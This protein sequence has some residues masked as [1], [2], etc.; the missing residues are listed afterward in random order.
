MIKFYLNGQR[1]F[2][3]RGCEA[4]VRSTVSLLKRKFGDVQV[5]VPSDNISLDK[6]QWEDYDEYGVKF[7]PIYYPKLTRVWVQ[8][9]RLPL[10]F[11]KRMN[12]PFFVTPELKNI[13]MNI[14]AVISIGG[15]MYTYE[16]RLPAWIMGVDSIA[17]KY[18]KPVILWGASISDFHQEP[19]FKEVLQKHFKKMSRLIV[20]ESISQCILKADFDIESAVKMPDSAFTLVSQEVSVDAF[21]P[22][23]EGN[24]VLGLNVSPLIE[25]LNNEKFNIID[26]ISNFVRIVI[27][28]HGL[29]VLFVPHVTPLDGSEKNSDYHYM[30]RILNKLSDLKEQIG[31]MD[32]SLN[33]V[34]TKYVISQCR[35]FVGART[36][37]TIAA[38]SSEVPTVSIAYSTKAKGIN[39]DLFGSKPVVVPLND[40]SSENLLNAVDYL[41]E[42]EKE[43]KKELATKILLLKSR[44]YEVTDQLDSVF[45]S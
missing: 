42:N 28:K 24:G 25:K 7:V 13:L 16:G 9:Q 20:R 30:M 23:N 8:L 39:A 3:N 5:Y 38:F 36:H 43:I 15:D 45:L 29:S 19:E 6:K 10:K 34:Q 21:W 14:D 37:S 11:I 27:E 4:L 31:I 26:E 17:M 22:N 18:D 1:T 2:S 12:W 32:S 35:F 44:I 33:A 40:L 41:V